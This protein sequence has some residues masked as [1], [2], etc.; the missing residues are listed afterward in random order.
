MQS[1]IGG[2]S[3]V[4]TPLLDLKTDLNHYTIFIS[5]K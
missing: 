5:K 1:S 4:L 2:L 3:Y